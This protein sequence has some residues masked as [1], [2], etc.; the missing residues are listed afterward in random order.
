MPSGGPDRQFV[1]QPENITV[2]GGALDAPN[3][4]VPIAQRGVEGA[5]PYI[6]ISNSEKPCYTIY[7]Y[8]EVRPWQN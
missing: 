6:F 5:A 8:K 7:N 2:G 4:N 3:K 1:T